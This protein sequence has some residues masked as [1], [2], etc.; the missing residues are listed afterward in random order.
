MAL[1][2]AEAE[3]VDVALAVAV[4]LA[5]LA[6]VL[7]MLPAPPPPAAV[8][9]RPAGA[10]GPGS[11]LAAVPKTAVAVLPSLA[12]EVPEPELEVLPHRHTAMTCAGLTN[13]VRPARG[14][15]APAQRQSKAA[16]QSAAA[17]LLR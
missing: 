2:A 4:A 5:E 16:C 6:V 17:R 10:E 7:G 3:A 1:A 15:E 14:P 9:P 8:P 13:A 12:A 11:P